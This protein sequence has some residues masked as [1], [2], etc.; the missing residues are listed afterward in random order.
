[1]TIPHSITVRFLTWRILSALLHKLILFLL[2]PKT[3]IARIHSFFAN[4]EF[5]VIS[6]W[7]KMNILIDKLSFVV[8]YN[9]HN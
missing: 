1:M 7:V 5:K 2:T 9:I 4:M 3:E 6:K 8:Y